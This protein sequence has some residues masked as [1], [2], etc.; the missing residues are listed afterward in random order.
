MSIDPT[1]IHTIAVDLDGTL[2]NSK[3]KISPLTHS[4]LQKAIDQGKN[5]VIATEAVEKCRPKF[6]KMP[7]KDY[8]F[9]LY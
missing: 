9:R 5:L 4:V 7:L 6:P 2:L 1:Q 3:S 8:V